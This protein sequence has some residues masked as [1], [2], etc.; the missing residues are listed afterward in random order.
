MSAEFY[1]VVFMRRRIKAAPNAMAIP[2]AMA[3]MGNPGIGLGTLSSPPDET[4]IWR[5]ICPDTQ[6]IAVTSRISSS[7]ASRSKVSDID[8]VWDWLV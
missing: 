5:T 4:V 2:I 8:D 7:A 3:V 6:H 1:F